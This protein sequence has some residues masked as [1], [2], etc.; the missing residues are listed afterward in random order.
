MRKQ[1]QQLKQEL[2]AESEKLSKLYTESHFQKARRLTSHLAAC[3]LF[4][5]LR[6]VQ[7]IMTKQCIGIRKNNWTQCEHKAR[8][9]GSQCLGFCGKHTEQACNAAHYCQLLDDSNLDPKHKLLSKVLHLYHHR[10]H[11]LVQAHLQQQ[12]Q[13]Q[14]IPVNLIYRKLHSDVLGH[15]DQFLDIVDLEQFRQMGWS[16]DAT[17]VK[18]RTIRPLPLFAQPETLEAIRSVMIAWNYAIPLPRWSFCWK[19]LLKPMANT[20]KLIEELKQLAKSNNTSQFVVL[21]V[22]PI[23][24]RADTKDYHGY[25]PKQMLCNNLLYSLKSVPANQIVCEDGVY[26]FKQNNIPE[27]TDI[28]KIV[29]NVDLINKFLKACPYF[30][31]Y[32][33]CLIS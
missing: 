8:Y 20:F 32:L 19:D 3:L 7:N 33:S 27:Y 18:G 22:A 16:R 29:L 31:W 28:G 17:A 14:Q 2:E 24:V 13:Q 4:A 30:S 25:D 21:K 10:V 26:H 5:C 12:Q 23:I 9:Y 1:R 6:G 15:V 11:P